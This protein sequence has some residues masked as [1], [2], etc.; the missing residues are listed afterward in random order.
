MAKTRASSQKRSGRREPE[1]ERPTTGLHRGKCS[2]CRHPE[3][4][5]IER[6][7]IG[8]TSPHEIARA[9]GLR[10]HTTVYRH[11]HARGLFEHRQRNLHAALGRVIGHVGEVEPKG[12]N[13]IA[14]I[15]MMAGINPQEHWAG[16]GRFSLLEAFDRMTWETAEGDQYRRQLKAVMNGEPSV[17]AGPP[18]PLA[19]ETLEPEEEVEDQPQQE[20][21]TEPEARIEPESAGPE[22]SDG[23]ASRPEQRETGKEE[24][25][26]RSVGL[27]MSF[28]QLP[29]IPLCRRRGPGAGA[30]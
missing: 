4:M 5:E 9:Y 28:A 12:S 3:R 6:A 2:I 29:G 30:T 8:W 1:I 16:S 18:L 22:P 10:S 7:F 20:E 11:A 21:E 19:Q 13:I 17:E 15:A 26:G 14:A 23:H 25:G 24:A 27:P